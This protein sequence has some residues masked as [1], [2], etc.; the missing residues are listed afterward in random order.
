[1]I[2]RSNPR[3]RSAARRAARWPIALAVLVSAFV[4]ITSVSTAETITT[5]QARVAS[6]EFLA[7]AAAPP[8]IGAIC[9]IDTGVD[10]TPDTSRVVA[11]ISA[12]DDTVGDT[13]PT[14]HGTLVA[15]L[16][17]A[18]RNDWG[19]VGIWPSGR[20]VS[21]RANASG[22]EFTVA[23]YYA[24][25]QRCDSVA[26]YYG[27][28]TILLA[29]GSQATPTEEEATALK[30]RLANARAHGLNVL[31]AA[32]NN[33]GGPLETPAQLPGALSVGGSGADGGRCAISAIGAALQ[34]PGCGV[35]AI[36]PASGG[37]ASFQGTTASAAV[38]AAAVSALRSYRPDLSP[39][40][41]DQLLL[42]TATPTP[43]G[44]LL[45]VAAAFRAAGLASIV[46]SSP[47]LGTPP[48]SPP[49]D[50]GRRDLAPKSRLPRPKARVRRVPGHPRRLGV[51]LQNLP[52]RAV[53]EVS[54]ADR[55]SRGRTHR[56]RVLA[57]KRVRERATQVRVPVRR[58]VRVTIRYRDPSGARL[59]S[60]PLVVRVGA[61][62]RR[63]R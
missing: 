27:I 10:Q 23:S 54:V 36:D 61:A 21:I 48:T 56:V 29:L 8:S 4:S 50:D 25:L 18:P 12:W 13:S 20:I 49:P 60:R 59:T 24:G 31:V 9:L 2:S 19:M 39:D 33:G 45:N 14:R 37:P 11:R 44:P 6:A 55:K 34:A 43:A 28:N 7:T 51:R 15:A 62:S 42:S 38:A 17:S 57:R 1:V 3:L 53:T 35:D 32:G 63:A 16:L 30:E 26:G 5:S 46:D 47:P 22:D 40:A 41:A 58:A 52:R